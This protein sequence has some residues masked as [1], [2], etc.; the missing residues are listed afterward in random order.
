MLNRR[1]KGK[2][3]NL[4]KSQ[5]QDVK[6]DIELTN[7]EKKE[8]A[9]TETSTDHGLKKGET[10]Q[11]EMKDQVEDIK[12]LRKSVNKDNVQ[13]VDTTQ[14]VKE[15]EKL[16]QETLKTVIEED[17][18]DITETIKKYIPSYDIDEVTIQKIDEIQEWAAKDYSKLYRLFT[19]FQSH[20]YRQNG[21]KTLQTRW[22]WKLKNDNLP[23]QD[24]TVR[25]FFLSLYMDILKGMPDFVLLRKMAVDN[26]YSLESGKVIDEETKD[27][28]VKLHQD[29][30]VDGYIRRFIAT[31]GHKISGENNTARYPAVLHPVDYQLNNYFLNHQLVQP[32]TTQQIYDLI[33]EQLH[34]DPN[35]VFTIDSAF[36][37]NSRH[38]PPYLLQDRLNLHDGFESIWE[39][40]THANYLN[41]RRYVPDL[42]ELV[43]ADKQIRDMAA[44]LQLEAITVQIESQF[45]SGINAASA[46]EAFKIIIV[47]VLSTR[48]IV[49]DFIAS[50]YMSLLSCMYLLSIYPQEL[51]LRESLVSVQ[52]AI[53]NTLIY[54]AIGLPQMHYVAGEVRTPFQIAEPLINNRAIRN[55]LHHCNTLTFR[56]VQIN[57]VIYLRFPDEIMTGR[58]MDLY[59]N[60]LTTL[61]NQ[62]FA[63]Y[64]F[65]YKRSV[66]RAITLVSNRVA[67]LSDLTRLIVYNYTTLS[68]CIV[69][70]MHVSR[71]LTLEHITATSISSL[72]MLISN[73]TAIPD[74]RGLFKYYQSNINYLTNYNE[75]ID[76]TVAHIMAAYRLNLHQLKMIKIMTEFL[77]SLKIFDAPKVPP[78][79]M[80]RLR[81]RMRGIQLEQ[82]RTDVFNIVMNNRKLIEDTS[83]QI[84]QGVLL[85]YRPLPL[86]HVENEGLV[87]IVDD[88]TQYLTLNLEEIQMTGD[89]T[90]ITNALLNDIPVVLQGAIPFSTNNSVLDVLAKMDSTIFAHIVKD[91]DITKLK[92]IKFVVNSDSTDYYLVYNNQ[93]IPTTSTALYKAR[94]QLFDISQATFNMESSLFFEVYK[95]LFEYVKTT[96]VL[97]VNAVTYDGRKIMQEL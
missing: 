26:P 24:Y 58:I 96:T 31:M 6:T 4:N 63:T 57:G 20:I 82:R 3:T 5:K 41:A 38:V 62:N 80:Y 35:Y 90:A 39:T 48:A 12:A 84:C 37:T 19:P 72:I 50:N 79:Q 78:D 8:L 64:S 66:Q 67:Q 97:P 36:L 77:A 16:Q 88:N 68:S 60:M 92:P 71:T 34:N 87:N 18:L 93:W 42:T 69:M 40:F 81:N 65:D 55:W 45:L 1:G 61:A 91:R 85:S 9:E 46:N 59:A 51:V 7:D 74:P 25:E 53:I 95:D 22:Y 11:S 21:E 43:D 10:V 15:V 83:N 23:A 29:Q 14:L 76:N 13:N 73:H 33:P 52:L 70:S 89:Y 49:I 86:Q 32:L 27:I 17:K 2:Q 28:L 94:S 47:S 75:Q 30:M 44:H 54:P 56:R